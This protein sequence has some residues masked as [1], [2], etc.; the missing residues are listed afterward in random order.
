MPLCGRCGK[1]HKTVEVV[2]ECHRTARKQVKSSQG[3]GSGSKSSTIGQVNPPQ[4]VG[5][6][7][8]YHSHL[9]RHPPND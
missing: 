9:D 1:H 8:A 4:T 3:S 5:L 6:R 7:H 2:R